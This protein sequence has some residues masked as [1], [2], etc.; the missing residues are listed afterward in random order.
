MDERGRSV[1]PHDGPEAETLIGFL[2][3]QRVTLE[4]KCSGLSDEQLR[5]TLSPS[6][7][8]LGGLLKH[9]ACVED[10]V[11]RGGGGSTAS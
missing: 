4:R 3:Y 10:L 9:L 5:L 6:P 11:H 8:T 2:G 7:I 1:P